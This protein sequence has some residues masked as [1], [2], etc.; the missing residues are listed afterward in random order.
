MPSLY[1][2]FGIVALEAMV[3]GVPTVVA[4][5]CGLG[6]IVDHG[7]DGMKAYTGNAN[8]LADCILEIL[9]NPNKAEEVKRN[10]IKKV[11]SMYNW[12][13]ISDETLKAYQEIVAK[14]QGIKKE[15]KG[16]V[17]KEVKKAVK[18]VA[19]PA[20][21][22]EEKVKEKTVEPKKVKKEAKVAK[23]TKKEEK[24][25]TKKEVKKKEKVKI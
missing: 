23:D 16:E 24:K 25:V 4:D 1:E 7:V 17:K 9:H 21:K 6:E 2:P 3:A 10:A 11:H 5:T 15:V 22:K 13:K 12:D 19:K 18:K 8:S 14:H 20:K